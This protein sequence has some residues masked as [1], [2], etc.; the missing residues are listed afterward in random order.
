MMLRKVK[1][2]FPEC[3]RIEAVAS[4]PDWRL[5][6]SPPRVDH[7]QL[8]GIAIARDFFLRG[9]RIADAPDG[10]ARDRRALVLIRRFQIRGKCGLKRGKTSSRIHRNL[11][12]RGQIFRF[13][14]WVRW[15][16]RRIR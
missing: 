4:R 2:A 15:S 16:G 8:R 1:A 10:L 13:V 14:V 9:L 5:A 6:I 3:Q 11:E 12:D 7:L